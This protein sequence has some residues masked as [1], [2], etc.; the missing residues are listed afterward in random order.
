MFS[1]TGNRYEKTP[2]VQKLDSTI[3]P[4]DSIQWMRGREINYVIR[5][6][7]DLSN[8]PKLH[9]QRVDNAFH[10]INLYP[11]SEWRLGFSDFYPLDHEPVQA[12]DCNWGQMTLPA[13]NSCTI[14]IIEPRLIDLLNTVYER[15]HP[16]GPGE[17]FS[18]S[19][20]LLIV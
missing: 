4:L 15:T 17:P 8:W 13:G 2:V 10:W 18:F 6:V 11:L 9:V 14:E 7:K 1:L 20:Q 3:Y 5:L 12:F 19:F 16:D